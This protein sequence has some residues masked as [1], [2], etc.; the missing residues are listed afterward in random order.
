VNRKLLVLAVLVLVFI[1]FLLSTVTTIADDTADVA[2]DVN[3]TEAASITVVPAYL[4]WTQVSTGTPGGYKNLTVKNAGSLNLSQIYA[5][6][7][8]TTDETSRPIGSSDPADFAA[9]GVI[10]IRN[11]TNTKYYFAGRLEWNWTQDIPSHNWGA[12]T[13]PVS[14]GFFRNTSSDYVWVLGNGTAAIGDA[15]G[16]YCNDS[17]QFSIETEVD[18]GTTLTRTPDNTI[19]LT[20]SSNNPQNWS[21]GN[22]TSG[23]LNGHC[24]AAFFNCSKIYIF[25]YDERSNFTDCAN[26]DYLRV[27]NLTPGNTF[28]N[29]VDAWVPNGI[30]S[31]NMSQAT[32]TF[33]ASSS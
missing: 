16:I 7:D 30:P 23:P 28:I 24:V 5:Y 33:Y 8:T 13:S 21:Y 1:G 32:L 25:K 11:E 22:M 6:V 31:G 19:L 18:L 14:W 4:N 10:T 12:V 3:V 29:R 20:P 26:T 17:A 15:D 2:I 9:G 27:A